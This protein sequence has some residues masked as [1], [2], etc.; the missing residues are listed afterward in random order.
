MCL[1]SKSE[2][3]SHWNLVRQ[4][5]QRQCPAYFSCLI[6]VTLFMNTLLCLKSIHKCHVLTNIFSEYLLKYTYIISLSPCPD[7]HNFIAF[8]N[9]LHYIIY[10]FSVFPSEHK[11]IRKYHE[12]NRYRKIEISLT[13]KL[14]SL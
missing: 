8:I 2:F 4:V 5:L 10:S 1:S 6:S 14:L 11:H 12:R 3:A 13:L 7:S 9:I